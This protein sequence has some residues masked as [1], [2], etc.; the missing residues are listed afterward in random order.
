ML[1]S[2]RIQNFRSI[3]DASVKLGQV[4]LFIGPNNSGKSNFLKG[5]SETAMR[6]S[7]Y[8]DG[9]EVSIDWY[10]QNVPRGDKKDRFSPTE[11][12]IHLVDQIDTK[13][14][15]EVIYSV[16]SKPRITELE[17]QSRLE[18]ELVN[19]EYGTRESLDL[20][21]AKTNFKAFPQ[22]F[23][24]TWER[25]ANSVIYKIEPA[26]FEISS[27]LSAQ[28]L[29]NARGINIANFINTLGQNNESIIIN[30]K[31]DFAKCVRSLISFSTPPDPVFKGNLKLKFF[32][33]SGNSYWAEEVS[34]GVLYFLAL[35]CIVHQPDPP[36][37]LLLEEPEKGIHPRRIKEVMDFIFELAEL[38]GIQI[39]LTSH[40]PYVVDHFAD[41]PECISVFDRENDETVIRNAGDII[42]ATNAR[43][44]AEGKPPIRYTDSLGEHWVSGFL[45]GVPA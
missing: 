22:G 33:A 38:R 43:L 1:T 24:G 19:T 8:P 17:M 31:R 6:V 13:K 45:G 30:L 18:A 4:N 7:D 21:A 10:G 26:V 25:L 35:L 12:Q 37:L 20:S 11:I 34:E 16:T 3:R 23:Y 42:T 39:I 2:L 29:L 32:D 40:S 9:Q 28:P 44:E 14:F 36:K 15:C 27:G 41:I 5:I